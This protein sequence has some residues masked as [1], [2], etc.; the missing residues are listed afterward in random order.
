MIA[1]IYTDG[2]SRSNPGKSASGYMIIDEENNLLVKDSFYNGIKTNNE[3]EYLAIIAALER[4]AEQFGYD[5]EINLFSDSQLVV[6]QLNKVYKV[7][8]TGL[9]ELNR[10]AGELAKKFSSCKLENVSR[11]NKYISMV[12]RELNLLL[13]GLEKGK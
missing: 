11:E 12:D 9:K 6:R 2:A 4:A 1:N 5:A 10:K 7:K 13:D 8:E 3:A